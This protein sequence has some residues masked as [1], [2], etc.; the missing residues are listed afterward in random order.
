MRITKLHLENFRCY[1]ALDIDFEK[2]L[3]VIVGENGHGKTAIFDAISIC[4]EPYL[5]VFKHKGLHISPKDVRRAPIYDE[6]GH[7]TG[8]QSMLP[9]RIDLEIATEDSTCYTCSKIYDQEGERVLN[10]TLSNLATVLE[11]SLDKKLPI[12]A[13]YGTSRLWRDSKLLEEKHKSMEDRALGYQ[14]CLDPSASF[15]TFGKWLEYI[16]TR[17]E[18]IFTHTRTAVLQAIDSCLKSTGLHGI[19]FNKQLDALVINHPVMGEQLVSDLS[20]GVR[21]IISIA[22]DIAYRMVRLNAQLGNRVILDTPGVIFIDE[23]DMHLHPLWQQYVLGD[24]QATFPSVQFIITTHSPQVLSTVPPEAIRILVWGKKFE[25]VFSTDF[26]LGAE[27]NQLLQDIQ[28]VHTRPAALPIVQKLEHYLDL[29]ALDKWD[30]PEALALREEL[31]Q[32]SK[33]REPLLVKADMDI[34]MRKFRRSRS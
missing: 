7:L 10:N 32:W 2:D 11:G 18:L 8:M 28:H 1:E 3:N 20:D 26:S 30:T 22:V 23:L 9:V 13:Y 14:E 19:Y 27:S 24:L 17:K 29:V 16:S 34:R 25:G 33:G 31:D 12:L 21:T 4:L 15:N 6:K 5:H